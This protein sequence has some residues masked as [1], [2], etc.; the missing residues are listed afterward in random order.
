LLAGTPQRGAQFSPDDSWI[1]AFGNDNTA[2]IWDARTG[3]RKHTLRHQ[4]QVLHTQWSKDGRKVAT[5]GMDNT[6]CVWDVETGRRVCRVQHQGRVV[7]LDF[8]PDGL[9]FVTGS[10]DSTAQIWDAESG[11]PRFAAPWRLEGRI[12]QVAFSP[13]GDQVLAVAD[14]RVARVWDARTGAPRSELLRHEDQMWFGTFSPDGRRIVTCAMGGALTI[15]DPSTNRRLADMRHD[16]TVA[17]A[18]F[19]PD[20]RRLVSASYDH[21]ARVWD[22]QTGKPLIE[23]LRH[24]D[25][26]HRAS[27]SP[28]GRLVATASQDG[29]ARVWDAATGRAMTEPLRD[30]QAVHHVQFSR[31]GQWLATSSRF[32]RIW[33]LPPPITVAPE[34][35]AALAESVAGQ[36]VDE[37]GRLAPVSADALAALKQ[38]F[39][40]SE[41]ANAWTAWARWFF[42][43]R[44]TRALSPSHVVRVREMAQRLAGVDSMEGCH[45]AV[46]L[47]PTNGLAWA[48]LAAKVMEQPETENS[49]RRAQALHYSHRALTL[50]SHE[51]EVWL[52]RTRILDQNGLAAE[53]LSL[54]ERGTDQFPQN[55]SLWRARAELLLRQGDRP[56]DAYAALTRAIELT[57]D[58][59]PDRVAALLLK[60]RALALQSDRPEEAQ[61]D[62]LRAMKVSPR[63]AALP[64]RCLDLS[65]HYNA[66]FHQDWHGAMWPGNNLSSLPT[67][68]QSFGGVDFDVRGIVQLAGLQINRSAPGFPESVRGIAVQQR[69]RRLHFLHAAGWVSSVPAG[70]SIGHL[71]AHYADGEHAELPLVPGGNTASWHAPTNGPESL[72]QATTVWTGKSA[73]RASAVRLF[74]WT[75]DNPRPEV[76]IASLDFTSA[77]TDAAPFLVAVTVEP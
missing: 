40:R 18:E 7:T 49:L 14:S 20:G 10:F 8:S 12:W 56:D 28:N 3:E 59:E 64:A 58:A 35:L 70:T 16:S 57:Q 42:A 62:W 47:A 37:S 32:A 45:E 22:A 53:A 36:A 41:P 51:P 43:D 68:R 61:R 24:L 25:E 66:A 48:R 65:S 4:G 71:V 9:S 60:R 63:D 52:A 29:T 1:L 17:W 30:V 33:E 73:W 69:G 34:W 23:P 74:L 27:F 6:A 11:Q 75:W 44:S 50:S 13:Q 39:S 5:G 72:P 31:N 46:R 55:G 67:G 54:L 26:V 21:T 19:S 38:R 76:E 2:A 77:M 15:W